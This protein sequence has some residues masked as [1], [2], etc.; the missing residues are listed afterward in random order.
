LTQGFYQIPMSP[1]DSLKTAFSIPYGHY[2]YKRMPLGLKNAPATFQRLMDSILTGLQ[3]NELFIYLD[4]IVVYVRS[5][6]EHK[7]KINRWQN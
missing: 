1:N 3:G 2:E 7:I 5:L 4:D 6:E